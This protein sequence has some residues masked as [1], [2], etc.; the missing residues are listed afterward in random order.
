MDKIIIDKN[1]DIRDFTDFR[2]YKADIKAYS[3][4]IADF[5]IS[6]RFLIHPDFQRE[7]VWPIKKASTLIETILLSLPIPGIYTY[8]NLGTGQEIVIDGQQRLTTIKKIYK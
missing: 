6:K 2:N 4:R 7:Y 1:R 8:I 3:L 5:I